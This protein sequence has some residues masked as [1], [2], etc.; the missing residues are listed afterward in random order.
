MPAGGRTK[1]SAK[2]KQGAMAKAA[3][4]ARRQSVVLQS[5]AGKRAKTIVAEE[6]AEEDDLVASG[7][8]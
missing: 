1:K 2:V 8:E 3:L 4:M 5:K 6:E 7:D